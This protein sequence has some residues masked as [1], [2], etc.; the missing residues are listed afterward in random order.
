[1]KKLL[2]LT[3]GC[4]LTFAPEASAYT[5]PLD[6]LVSRWQ[7]EGNAFDSHGPN[8]GT[9]VDGATFAVGMIGQAFSF[10][11]VGARVLVPSDPTLDFTGLWE[12]SF[13]AWV[14]TTR[15]Y[16]PGNSGKVIEQ[17]GGI[18]STIDLGV[19]RK[20]AV[21]AVEPTD[22]DP[23]SAQG[24]HDVND[25]KWHLIAGVLTGTSLQSYTDGALQREAPF[26]VPVAETSSITLG[27]QGSVFEGLADEIAI[28]DRPLT[29]AEIRSIYESAG[30]PCDL[31]ARMWEYPDTIGRGETFSFTASAYNDC[32]AAHDFDE[33]VMTV[34]GPA[35]LTKP[36]YD[37][38]PISVP[39]ENSM[40]TQV[41]LP[42]PSGAP[43]GLY[44]IEIS[45][46][47][48]GTLIDSAAAEVR[49]E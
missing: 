40:G 23:I 8:D 44:T 46:Y 3:F 41:N 32:L 26:A 37:G 10:N 21:I 16:D 39:A 14:K 27:G 36:L 5:I 43:T 49:V 33:A 34:T 48:T 38:A 1:M 22:C 20:T 19:A 15:E 45:L 12:G 29:G 17:L 6:G 24:W 42:V 25:G 7:A 35:G 31:Y 11:G 30:V 4:Y 47:R 9:L 28:Y 18:C 2:I 13:L